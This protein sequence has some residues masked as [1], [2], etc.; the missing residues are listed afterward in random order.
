MPF[1]SRMSLPE[2]DEYTAL[3]KRK[4]YLFMVGEV[5]ERSAR[6][7]TA[8]ALYA[9]NVH[10]NGL[11]LIINSMGGEIYMGLGLYDTFYGLRNQ[12]RTLVVGHAMSMAT[13]LVLA[14]KKGLRFATPNARFMIHP[15]RTYSE[16]RTADIRVD[17][18]EMAHMQ[19]EMLDIYTRRT[20]KARKEFNRIFN[21]NKDT[22]LSAEQAK[23][24][25]LIDHIVPSFY[26]MERITKARLNKAK[27]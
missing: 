11:T 20:G 15:V 6:E 24:I 18:D 2:F 13:I 22:Y 12:L 1:M 3:A 25:G 19:R 9:D 17:A 21:K 14:G 7:L 27:E 10:K 5:D 23:E 8:H 16:G 4:G 26:A